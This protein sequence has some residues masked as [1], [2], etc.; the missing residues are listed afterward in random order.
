MNKRGEVTYK[1]QFMPWRKKRLISG[2][3]TNPFKQTCEE[4]QV[5]AVANQ[6]LLK[7]MEK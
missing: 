3:E 7:A 6:S 5:K 4:K 1:D 2:G